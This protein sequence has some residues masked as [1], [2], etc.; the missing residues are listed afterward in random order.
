M[1]GKDF[2]LSSYLFRAYIHSVDKQDEQ[3]TLWGRDDFVS[4][5]LPG[6]VNIFVSG[7]AGRARPAPVPRPQSRY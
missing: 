4:N 5:L 7:T 2:Q 6:R 3:S 1:K